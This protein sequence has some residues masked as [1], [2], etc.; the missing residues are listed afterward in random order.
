MQWGNGTSLQPRISPCQIPRLEA[1][2]L[3]LPLF[4]LS[5]GGGEDHGV[6]KRKCKMALNRASLTASS[7]SPGQKPK[8]GRGSQT[9]VSSGRTEYIGLTFLCLSALYWRQCSQGAALNGSLCD[10]CLIRNGSEAPLPGNRWRCG[11]AAP[12]QSHGGLCL[13][14]LYKCV[15]FI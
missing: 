12:E 8:E 3:L 13:K 4:G 10:R 14:S 6:C 15:S 2:I 11:K 7:Q 9:V 1:G 5:P